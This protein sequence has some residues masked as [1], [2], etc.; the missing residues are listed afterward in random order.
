MPKIAYNMSGDCMD[1]FYLV[2]KPKGLTSHDVVSYLKKKLNLN[3]IGHTG[4][5]DPFATGLLILC[6]GK[7]TKL[8]DYISNQDKSYLGTILFGVHTDTYDLTGQ[9]L[10]EEPC[11]LNTDQIKHAMQQMVKSYDQTPPNYS[12][13]KTKGQKAYDMARKGVSFSLEKRPVT[14]FAFQATSTYENQMIDFST[15]VSKGTYIRSLVV[16]LATNLQTYAA[17]NALKRTRIG[18]YTLEMA[19][20]MQD[21]MPDDLLSLETYFKHYQKLTLSPYLIHLVKN[22]VYLDHRQITTDQPF[23]VY[24][25]DGQ[26]IAFYDVIKENTYKPV[27]IF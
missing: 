10:K 15:S 8:S 20:D 4:T 24:N 12:A 23:I 17:L 11:E 9:I 19:K 2:N 7:A 5:L 18:A 13:I 14:I 3:K 21:I 26:M 1:G 16:D 6:V 25:E 27:L 22:G